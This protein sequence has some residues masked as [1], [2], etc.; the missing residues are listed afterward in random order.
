M[1]KYLIVAGQLET[2]TIGINFNKQ[3]QADFPFLLKKTYSETDFG[4][5]IIQKVSKIYEGTFDEQDLYFINLAKEN[6]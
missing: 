6:R 2:R 5:A 1:N 3:Y 4:E